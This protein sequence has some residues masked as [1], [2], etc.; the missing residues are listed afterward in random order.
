ML[1]RDSLLSES[2]PG[3]NAELLNA[4]GTYSN[5]CVWAVTAEAV[6]RQFPTAETRV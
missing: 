3:E 2:Q 4:C 5:Q 1:F 6:S